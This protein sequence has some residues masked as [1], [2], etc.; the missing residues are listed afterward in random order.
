[1]V[2]YLYLLPKFNRRNYI[3]KDGKLDST[4]NYITLSTHLKMYKIK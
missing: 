3:L 4:M 2:S 1:M